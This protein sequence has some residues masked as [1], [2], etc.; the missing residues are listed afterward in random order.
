MRHELQESRDTA[1][2]ENKMLKI[3]H[4]ETKEKELRITVDAAYISNTI[5]NILDDKA[6]HVSIKII[7]D[8]I[9]GFGSL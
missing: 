8:K 5:K 6:K 2:L 1:I 9:F 3:F 4:P 7:D